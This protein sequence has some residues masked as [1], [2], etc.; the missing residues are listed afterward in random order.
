MRI[1]G[2]RYIKLSP[3]DAWVEDLAVRFDG[4]YVRNH[5][6]YI[7]RLIMERMLDRS[8]VK[9]EIVDHINGDKLDNRRENLRVTDV[10]TNT[11]N[12]KLTKRNSSGYKGVSLASDG[13]RYEARVMSN[14]RIVWRSTFD[15]P[16]EAAE[17]Y[18]T[19]RSELFGDKWQD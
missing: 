1:R 16:E 6:A 15:S 11:R 7:H 17:A 13:R 9:G 5:D 3:E 14:Y 19:K 10:S 2:D 12:C 4:R 8:L 18:L